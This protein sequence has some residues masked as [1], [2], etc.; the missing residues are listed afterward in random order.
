MSSDEIEH[1]RQRAADERTRAAASPTHEL[2]QAHLNLAIMYEN[3]VER[4]GRSAQAQ[5]VLLILRTEQP[6]RSDTRQ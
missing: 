4:L 6:P 5:D 3:L 2:A 1:Y